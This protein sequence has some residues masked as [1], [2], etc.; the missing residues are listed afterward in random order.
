MFEIFLVVL[1]L[2]LHSW[3]YYNNLL[4]KEKVNVLN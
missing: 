2:A 4:H 1:V 3:E